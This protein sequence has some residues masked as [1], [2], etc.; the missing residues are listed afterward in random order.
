MQSNDQKQDLTVKGESVER[1]YGNYR[2]MRYIVNRRYQRKLVWTL[3][4]KRKFIDS[5]ANGYPVPIILLAESRKGEKNFLDIID[6]MQRMNA[7]MGFLENEYLVGD[8]YFD[9]NTMADTKALLD[10][11]I[12]IQRQ[13][14]LPRSTCVRIASYT[15]PLSIYEFS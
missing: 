6:G 7:I 4:E 15:V 3:D 5:I 14:V 1:I 2:E 10:S 12:I 13:P 9:L 11:G 8:G